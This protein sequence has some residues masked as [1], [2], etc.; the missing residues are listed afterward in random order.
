MLVKKKSGTKRRKSRRNS[1]QSTVSSASISEGDSSQSNQMPV[2]RKESKIAGFVLAA[3]SITVA[4]SVTRVLHLHMFPHH[5]YLGV[6]C[7][8]VL[9]FVGVGGITHGVG[10]SARNMYSSLV[11]KVGFFSS[12]GSSVEQPSV[13][14]QPLEDAGPQVVSMRDAAHGGP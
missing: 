7:N 12:S 14:D 1:D 6:L 5:L 10:Q 3:L 8:S 2:E 11:G 4:F 9:P 13:N